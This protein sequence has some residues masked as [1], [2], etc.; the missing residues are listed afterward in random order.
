MVSLLIISFLL[1]LITLAAIFQLLKKVQE[2]EN[3]AKSDEFTGALERTLKEIKA[4]ND[5]LQAL[6]A[7]QKVYSKEEVK[8][9]N[10]VND[11]T[12]EKAPTNETQPIEEADVDHLIGDA[13]GYKLEASLESRVMQLH[14][15][16]LTIEEIAK[17]LNCGKTEAELIIRFYNK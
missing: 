9:E 12:T 8:Q 7:D 11:L 1:H 3:T 17:T 4:E 14:A 6:M 2:M 5:R 15:K 13:P 16:G 10:R